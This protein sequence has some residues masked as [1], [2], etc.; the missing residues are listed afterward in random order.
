MKETL[1]HR[2]R[3]LRLQNGLSVQ[4]LARMAKV[5]A[6]YI[7]AIEAGSRGSHVDKLTRIAQILGTNLT[8]LWPG[9]S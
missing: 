3:E 9:P 6:S 5:S 2:V 7:Y 1:G 8:D 4:E